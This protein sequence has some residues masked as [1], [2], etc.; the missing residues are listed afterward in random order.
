MAYYETILYTYMTCVH[1]EN[2]DC[3][4]SQNGKRKKK[5]EKNSDYNQ[6]VGY[7]NLWSVA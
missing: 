2:H 3:F 4:K 1:F 7:Q 5:K 6:F